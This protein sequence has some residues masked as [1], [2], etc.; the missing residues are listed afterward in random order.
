M[1]DT[2]QKPKRMST[3]FG[4]KKQLVTHAEENDD[5][6]DI[7]STPVPILDMSDMELLNISSRAD[8]FSDD[9]D[10][11]SDDNSS[12]TSNSSSNISL[13]D[14]YGGG[15]GTSSNASG[16]ST[17]KRSSMFNWRGTSPPRQTGDVP[18]R[19]TSSS[20]SSN[21]NIK[22]KIM[23]VS[24]LTPQDFDDLVKTHVKFDDSLKQQQKQILVTAKSGI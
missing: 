8:D 3:L 5:I 7:T 1:A 13:D 22:A 18:S 16:K 10:D 24:E 23:S 21:K 17:Q 20:S 12:V 15:G 2:T 19:T 9:T 11:D 6:S 4:S 14:I